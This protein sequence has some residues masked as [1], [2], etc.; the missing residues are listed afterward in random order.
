MSVVHTFRKGTVASRYEL[1]GIICPSSFG[2]LLLSTDTPKMLCEMVASMGPTKIGNDFIGYADIILIEPGERR[3]ITVKSTDETWFNCQE[4]DHLEIV[5]DL[6][7][8]VAEFRDL[9]QLAELSR[10]EFDDVYRR[11]IADPAYR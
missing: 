7:S 5:D 9:P 8:S 1:V 6:L 4:V 3:P 10:Q 11:R 2:E